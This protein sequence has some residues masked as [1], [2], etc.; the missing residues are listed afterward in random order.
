[1]DT[2]LKSLV[3]LIPLIIG[4]IRYR[5]IDRSYQLFV[6]LMLM[7]LV[8]ET[9]NFLSIKLFRTNAINFNIFSLIEGVY[10]IYIFHLW[11]FLQKQKRLFILLQVGITLLWIIENLVF[12]KITEFSPYYRLVY[13][14]II[15]LLSV[16]QVN[17]LVIHNSK[18]LLKN[19]QFL[20]CVGFIIFFM[21]QILYE[22]AYF[23]RHISP[24][25][26]TF[27]RRIMSLFVDMNIFINLYYA[28]AIFFIPEKEKLP[29]TLNKLD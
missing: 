26:K 21:Y 17:F 6:I 27:G 28:I 20:I 3:V 2:Y 25:S 9:N 23:I 19:G 8:N 1:M 29:F 4:L 14:F 11:G 5:K 10:V 13:S 7:Y 16:N 24:D 15:V 18:N 12:L 22:G